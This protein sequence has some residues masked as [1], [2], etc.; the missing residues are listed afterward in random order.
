MLP[1]GPLCVC[2][3]V[4]LSDAVKVSDGDTGCVG[5]TMA[6]PVMDCVAVRDTVM[7][8]VSVLVNVLTDGLSVTVAVG[9]GVTECD[10]L[11]LKD[12]DCEE[13]TVADWETD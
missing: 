8:G 11:G 6:E 10:R 1:D 3:T 5:V 9:D 12:G 13:D 7:R 4:E 2:D